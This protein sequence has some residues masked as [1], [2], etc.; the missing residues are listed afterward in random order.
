M[1]ALSNPQDAVGSA[2]VVLSKCPTNARHLTFNLSGKD[3]GAI[4]DVEAAAAPSGN[5]GGAPGQM[6][7][8]SFWQM[9]AASLQVLC[10]EEVKQALL[11]HSCMVAPGAIT[12]LNNLVVSAD[13]DE[14][15]LQARY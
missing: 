8:S 15:K 3:T 4:A 1:Q 11:G 5:L 9:Y 7:G 2:P 13:V 10:V 6:V 12:L 14:D